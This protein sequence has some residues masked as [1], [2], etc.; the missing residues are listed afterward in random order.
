MN[1][2]D[3]LKAS[4]QTVQDKMGSGARIGWILLRFV[5]RLSRAREKIMDLYTWII[6]FERC[7]HRYEKD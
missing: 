7:P 2:Y 6:R 3:A 5:G 4:I 1:E